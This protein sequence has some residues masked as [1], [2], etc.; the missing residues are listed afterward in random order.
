MKQELVER[1]ARLD[2]CALSDALDRL[3]Q[4]GVVLGLQALTVPRR[5]AGRVIT[6]QLEKAAGRPSTRHLGTAAIESSGPGDV[7]VV[8]HAGRLNV[9]GWGGLL[10]LGAVMRGVE[11]VIVD[12][13]CRDV[14]EGRDLGLPVYARAAVPLTA[15]GRVIETAWNEP[16]TIGDVSVAPGDLV[17]A[18][19][20]GVVFLPAAHAEEIIGTAEQ[21][22]ACEQA[23]AQALR[24]GRPITKVMGVSYEELLS[25]QK[26]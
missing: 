14:D 16:V 6:L 3:R 5:I 15:R 20:S 21:I 22:A 18:D 24:S 13:A 1:L 11:G 19:G 17:L 26:E 7:I 8:A 25:K 9:A 23:M 10:S 12:G 2:S 4:S